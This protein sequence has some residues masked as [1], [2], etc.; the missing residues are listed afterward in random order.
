[1]DGGMKGGKEEHIYPSFSVINA[2]SFESRGRAGGGGF[3]VCVSATTA[4]T[5]GGRAQ[6]HNQ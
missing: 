4:H 6:K 2:R 5:A 1:M 3:V